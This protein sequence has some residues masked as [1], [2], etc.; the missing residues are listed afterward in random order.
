LE[1]LAYNE[2]VPFMAPFAYLSASF[3]CVRKLW[4]RSAKITAAI[5]I[6]GS[7]RLCDSSKAVVNLR[8]GTS[9]RI[10]VEAR[11][12]S[13]ASVLQTMALF[14][15]PSEPPRN[16]L[17]SSRPTWN[18][19]RGPRSGLWVRKECQRICQIKKTVLMEIDFRSS[20]HAPAFRPRRAG[21]VWCCPRCWRGADESTDVTF[22][23]AAYRG[24]TWPGTVEGLHRRRRTWATP[25]SRGGLFPPTI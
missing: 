1:E 20:V 13:P 2:V 15:P 24:P 7:R 25:S 18:H 6:S 3:S 5:E 22:V 9:A 21:A 10:N 17:A 16:H 11:R 12:R 8:R 19:R 4:I 23:S 14:L